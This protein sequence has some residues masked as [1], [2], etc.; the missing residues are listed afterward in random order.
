MDLTHGYQ[1]LLVH[2][3]WRGSHYYYG[4]L[5]H[6][7]T[8]LR[9]SLILSWNLLYTFFMLCSL[10]PSWTST[11]FHLPELQIFEDRGSAPEKTLP[12]HTD[13][14]MARSCLEGDKTSPFFSDLGS[15]CSFGYTASNPL[16]HWEADCKEVTVW[17]SWLPR[18]KLRGAG[19]HVVESLS[20]PNVR[21]LVIPWP[22]A[23]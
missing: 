21:T 16:C 3:L 1:P 17:H 5:Y 20:S 11:F 7:W 10:G 13:Q 12:N 18:T 6:L 15:F 22:F 4:N 19:P 9:R 23:A 14:E 2:L 8:W